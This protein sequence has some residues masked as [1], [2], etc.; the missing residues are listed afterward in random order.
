MKKPIIGVIPLVDYTK[1]SLWMLPGY[2]D[3]IK[4]AGG[5]PMILPLTSDDDDLEAI[6]DLYD[7]F[8]FTGGHDLSPQLYGEDLSKECGEI[9]IERDEMEIALFPLV[10]QKNK[11]ALGICRGIQLMNVALGGTLYQDLPTQFSSSLEH[12]QKPPYD[13]PIHCV[14]IL[15]DT[16]LYDLLNEETIQVNSYHHQAIKDLAKALDV[17]ATSKDGL[18]E[19]VYAK[20]KTFIQAIQWHPEFMYLKDYHSQ[21]IFKQFVRACQ[22]EL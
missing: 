15:K 1:K 12:H 16:P 14:T 3:G 22:K 6:V 20:N 9:S 10:Y 5:I 7:G 2:M 17:M 18:I 11:P 8:L 21:M 19:A 4:Q 13:E